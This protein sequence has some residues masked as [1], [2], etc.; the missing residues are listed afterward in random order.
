MKG[1]PVQ[2]VKWGRERNEGQ[3]SFSCA[4]NSTLEP[5]P[6]LTTSKC[7]SHA[8]PPSVPWLQVRGATCTWYTFKPRM[9]YRVW[10]GSLSQSVHIYMKLTYIY[11]QNDRETHLI[12]LKMN[13]HAEL[14]YVP[15]MEINPSEQSNQQVQACFVVLWVRNSV[16]HWGTHLC[17]LATSY[18]CYFT[19]YFPQHFL[20][21]RGADAA[22]SG[23]TQSYIIF[24]ARDL[25]QS[26]ST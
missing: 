19:Q 7:C 17:T 14:A 23:N 4:S 22:L 20:I 18:D 5:V 3:S 26:T 15:I 10:I 9:A 13:L 6:A 11:L 21:G 16:F 8:I 24:L 12:Y 1:K 25:H 2:R